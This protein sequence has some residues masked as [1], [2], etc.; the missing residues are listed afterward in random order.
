MVIRD[1]EKGPLFDSD[2]RG[3]ALSIAIAIAVDRETRDLSDG[4]PS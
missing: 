4:D 2:L 1:R 3:V